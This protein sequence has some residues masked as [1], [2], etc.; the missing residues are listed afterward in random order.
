L[1]FPRLITQINGFDCLKYLVYCW[2]EFYL[3]SA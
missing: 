1:G 3:S 2:D